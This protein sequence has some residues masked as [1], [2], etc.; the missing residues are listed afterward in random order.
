[1]KNEWVKFIR[2]VNEPTVYRPGNWDEYESLIPPD[3][4]YDIFDEICDLRSIGDYRHADLLRDKLSLAGRYTENVF[5]RRF[6]DGEPIPRTLSPNL[7]AATNTGKLRMEFNK[8][9]SII[10]GSIIYNGKVYEI[11]LRLHV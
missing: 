10:K 9:D 3:R 7:M 2:T 8:E 1:M 6:Y 4:I 5:L 11:Y